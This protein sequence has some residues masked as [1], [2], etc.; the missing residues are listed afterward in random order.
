MHP[1]QDPAWLDNRLR[2]RAEEHRL[3]RLSSRN[4][5]F[6]VIDAS[7]FSVQ[8]SEL[9]TTLTYK[10]ER[11]GIQ[12][13]ANSPIPL[14]TGMILR[15]LTKTYDLLRFINADETRFANSAY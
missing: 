9:A 14:D 1:A 8:L 15:Q 2:E 12:T 7:K 3:R 11:E 4:P 13:F 6:T 5:D 10:V